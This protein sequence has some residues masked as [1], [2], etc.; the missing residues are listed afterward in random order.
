MMKT[1]SE[2]ETLFSCVRL[3]YE[4]AFKMREAEF[5]RVDDGDEEQKKLEISG[6]Q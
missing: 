4:T 5:P 6:H 3:Q 1:S 2:Y